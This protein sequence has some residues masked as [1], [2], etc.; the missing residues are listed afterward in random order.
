MKNIEGLSLVDLARALAVGDLSATE[1]LDAYL[2]RIATH[3]EALNAVVSLDEDGARARAAEADKA[4]ASGNPIGPLHGVPLTLKDAHDVAGLRTTVGTSDLDRVAGADSTVAAR[5]RA[6]GANLIGH[7]NVPA[8]LADYQSD[9]AI[10]G[11]TNNP[12]DLTRTP[13]GSSGG[14]A[15]AVAAELTPGEIGSDLSGSLRQPAAFCGVYSLKP[16]EHRVPLTGFLRTPGPRPVRV[17][18][19][20]GPIAR[21]LDDLELLMS[22]V[23]GP[24]GYDAEVSPVPFDHRPEMSPG[25]L[26]LAVAPTIPGAPIAGVLSDRVRE[27]AKGVSDAGGRVAEELPDVNWDE[28]LEQFGDLLNTL[29]GNPDDHR[30]SDY[31]TALHRRDIL[32]ATWDAFF[33]EYDALLMPAAATVAF[34]HS[35]GDVLDIDGQK[36]PYYQQGFLYAFS[37]LTGLP[38]LTIPVGTDTAGLPVGLQLIGPRWSEATLLAVARGLESTGITPGYQRPPLLGVG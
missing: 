23:V 15:A 16:T 7:T 37:S 38:A 13:G 6:A 19:C 22:V 32:I 2:E 12:W 29:T 28:Q 21:S 3:N 30:L 31:L 11:R 4:W 5:L 35:D 17:M 18:A 1:V 36:V 33:G 9:N 14:P 8:W 25:E 10:F 20:I 27:V 34:P 26:R 24:D